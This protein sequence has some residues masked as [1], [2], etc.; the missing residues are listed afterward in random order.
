M[1]D[2][3]CY[4]HT[5]IQPLQPT[6]HFT[7]T[8]TRAWYHALQ[9]ALR[10]IL[11]VALQAGGRRAREARE[12]TPGGEAEEEAAAGSPPGKSRV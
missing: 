3:A 2:G 5:R 11:V 8:H 7:V 4:I 9:H 1:P 10:V 12:R 6:K